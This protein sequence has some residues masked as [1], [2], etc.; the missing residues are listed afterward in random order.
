MT[1]SAMSRELKETAL[2]AAHGVG[3]LLCKEGKVS[4]VKADM[5]D[6]CIRRVS[7]RRH[8]AG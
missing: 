8:S 3:R 7:S 2:R 5:E 4:N 1:D 6:R